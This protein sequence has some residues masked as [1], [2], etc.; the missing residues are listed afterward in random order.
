MPLFGVPNYADFNSLW[1]PNI[2]GGQWQTGTVLVNGK[3]TTGSSLANL[4]NRFLAYKARTLDCTTGASQFRINLGRLRGI[5]TVI[6]PRHNLSRNANYTVNVYWDVAGTL[7]RGTISG[8]VYPQ[9]FPFGSV[10]FE[11]DSFWDGKLSAEKALGYTQPLIAVFDTPVVGW[12]VEVLINDTTNPAGYVELARV[13]VAPGYQPTVNI[14]LGSQVGVTDPTIKT[15]SLGEVDF[16]DQ[17]KRRRVAIVSIDYLPTNEA[18]ANFFDM[19]MLQGTSGQIF[20]SWDPADTANLYRH[21]F[22]A[23]PDKL[24]PLTAASYG[25][26]GAAWSLT[27]VVG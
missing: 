5:K 20:F 1:Q 11:D 2:S 15:T 26:M 22:L 16:F 10:S 17:R 3:Q 27:E 14:K 4:Q 9:T 21:S 24:D 8:S 23:T 12:I 7:L 25:Y 19:M 18:F 13:I 6:I